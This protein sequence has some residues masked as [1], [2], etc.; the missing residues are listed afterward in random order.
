MDKRDTVKLIF[1]FALTYI[2]LYFLPAIVKPIESFFDFFPYF[3]PIKFFPTHDWGFTLNPSML[4]YT[5]FLMPLIGFFFIYLL[6][7]WINDYF[8]TDFAKTIY[9][10][11]LFVVL[12]FIAFY[13][14]LYWYYSN[15]ASLAAAQG[16]I[17]SATDFFE[18]WGVLRD[19]A[20]LVFIFSGLAGWISYRI[21]QKVSENALEEKRNPVKPKKP[22]P[23]PA[24]KKEETFEVKLAQ[25]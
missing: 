19:S 3:N 4:D 13:V 12:S 6:I 7:D 1:L 2:I 21:M 18:F 10:P 9:F 23:K 14:Q 24:E 11:L 25:T 15:L 20:F 22:E 17:V 5:F 8:E 16:Q